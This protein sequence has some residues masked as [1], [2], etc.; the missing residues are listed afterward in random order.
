VDNAQREQS[1]PPPAYKPASRTLITPLGSLNSSLMNGV[2]RSMAGEGA[3]AGPSGK[4][5]TA[6]GGGGGGKGGAGSAAV[7]VA[8]AR[9]LITVRRTTA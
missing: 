5:L 2:F 6:G 3:L 9:R 8:F 4:G 7:D 1:P